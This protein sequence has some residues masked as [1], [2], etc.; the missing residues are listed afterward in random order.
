MMF[1]RRALAAILASGALAACATGSESGAGAWTRGP[2]NR[3][4]VS[5]PGVLSY[6]VM[7]PS[8]WT[9]S[10]TGARSPA[11]LNA[12]S[13]GGQATA[14]IGVARTAES[15]DRLAARLAAR[16]GVGDGLAAP[17][18]L[19][20]IP[21]QMG[22]GRRAEV[23]SVP[24]RS[25]GGAVIVAVISEPGAHAYQLLDASNGAAYDRAMPLMRNVVAS[26]RPEGR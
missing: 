17:N 1:R 4:M 24:R 2:D 8:D 9:G 22:G 19:A 16:A 23:F 11:R 25:G 6:S 15:A 14:E 5:E 12:G 10:A 20:P 13:G 26:Y 7:T 3:V 21:L 18:R